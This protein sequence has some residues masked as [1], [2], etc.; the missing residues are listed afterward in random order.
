MNKNTK[1]YK[2][3]ENIKSDKFFMN[4]QDPNVE[5]WALKA[6]NSTDCNKNNLRMYVRCIVPMIKVHSEDLY[7]EWLE[8]Y[9]PIMKSPRKYYLSQ[10]EY[11]DILLFLNSFAHSYQIFGWMKDKDKHAS[12]FI[13]I[14][15]GINL[16]S[17]LFQEGNNLICYAPKRAGKTN[18][19]IFF[20]KEILDKL[21]NY[22]IVTNI[23]H[24]FNDE[25]VHKVSW[26]ID[27][28]EIIMKNMKK[29]LALD[30]EIR[31]IKEK[32]ISIEKKKYEI[33]GNNLDKDLRELEYQ[34]PIPIPIPRYTYVFLCIDEGEATFSIMDSIFYK[35][36]KQFEDWD[37]LAG[38]FKTVQQWIYHRKLDCPSVIRESPNVISIMHKGIDADGKDTPGYKKDVIIELPRKDK[39]FK[40]T[41]I[42]DMGQ[43]F[44]TADPAR[45]KI[46]DEDH[47]EKSFYPKTALNLMY[48][49]DGL[50]LREKIDIVL[51]YISDTRKKISFTESEIMEICDGFIEAFSDDV[52]RFK[53][54]DGPL[55]EKHII[56]KYCEGKNIS[57]HQINKDIKDGLKLSAEKMFKEYLISLNMEQ[58]IYD[59]DMKIAD[60]IDI[61]KCFKKIS[62]EELKKLNTS[63][64]KQLLNFRERTNNGEIAY[65]NNGKS[66]EKIG[67]KKLTAIL[68]VGIDNV[69]NV[70][71]NK[72]EYKDI[73]ISR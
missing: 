41:N 5:Y 22:I 61:K 20:M 59:L 55:F 71:H 52:F 44:D 23:E 31:Q 43:Y 17:Y 33:I 68:A 37:N 48:K 13:D 40:F 35:D 51:K 3:S 29:N 69:R 4:K 36:L 25:R 14:Q 8:K 58:T 62:Y 32:N 72:K 53:K 9:D 7:K 12:E 65:L 57:I 66:A 1:K 54:K 6:I 60:I 26:M 24:R 34:E 73:L 64:N 11:D 15:F 30:E 21:G 16:L 19:M 18:M 47:P 10:D 67:E 42:P 56:Y 45:F 50:S 70:L 49:K 28:Q 27:A 39:M 2:D 63:N 38:K 46:I